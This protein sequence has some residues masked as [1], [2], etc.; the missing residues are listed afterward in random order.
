V[1]NFELPISFGKLIN[2]SEGQEKM[3]Y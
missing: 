2:L 3:V 1:I